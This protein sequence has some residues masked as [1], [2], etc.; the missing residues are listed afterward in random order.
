MALPSG[1]WMLR[2]YC[3]IF[4]LKDHIAKEAIYANYN[5]KVYK[6]QKTLLVALPF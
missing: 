3:S 2:D 6:K 4:L 5:I 1:R